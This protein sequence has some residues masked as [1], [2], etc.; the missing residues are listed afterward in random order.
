MLNIIMTDSKKNSSSSNDGKDTPPKPNPL[1]ALLQHESFQAIQKLMSKG[2]FCDPFR[3]EEDEST[4]RSA[5]LEDSIPEKQE[6]TSSEQTNTKVTII[7]SANVV[8]GQ[9]WNKNVLCVSPDNSSS[10]SSPSPQLWNSIFR[11]EIMPTNAAEGTTT[12]NNETSSTADPDMIVAPSETFENEFELQLPSDS[13]G[14]YD[15]LSL[16]RSASTEAGDDIQPAEA[17]TPKGAP[18]SPKVTFPLE[19]VVIVTTPRSSTWKI[20]TFVLL[21]STA[22][23]AALFVHPESGYDRN[24][25]EETFE[26]T[27]VTLQAQ[28][29]ECDR[30]IL[31][32]NRDTNCALQKLHTAAQ[33]EMQKCRAYA[34]GESD[35]LCFAQV[36]AQVLT[37]QVDRLATSLQ[38]TA[39]SVQT[40]CTRDNAQAMVSPVQEWTVQMVGQLQDRVHQE[41]VACEDFLMNSHTGTTCSL[42]RI[43]IQWKE[44]RDRTQV[45][46]QQ[47]QDRAHQ[48]YKVC[49]SYLGGQETTGADCSLER[50]Q[51]EWKRQTQMAMDKFKETQAML[52]EHQAQC[53][54][55]LVAGQTGTDC[56]LEHATIQWV[57]QREW[58]SSKAVE[59]QKRIKVE[60][61]AFQEH[62]KDTHTQPSQPQDVVIAEEDGVADAELDQEE[63]SDAD[64][65]ADLGE[66]EQN[67]TDDIKSLIRE[68]SLFAT[69]EVLI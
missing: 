19:E 23:F 4:P 43:H 65:V 53:Q 30:Y 47:L 5:F 55:Y 42:E 44:Q 56:L 52:L 18:Q 39:N 45:Q 34:N 32:G 2:S 37:N 33:L 60:A 57:H 69:T 10:F 26:N 29:K 50:V 36:S 7:T 20:L 11:S 35:T 3:P 48:E 25:L 40:T 38:E 14:E 62:L 49:Q 67:P 41:Y 9:G 17:H 31:Q 61:S 46:L 66:Q 8:E 1:D 63:D 16:A 13:T 28:V 21:W 15:F 6:R 22:F 59:L 54:S 12:I 58:M 51:L 68:V 24:W 27:Q 64:A